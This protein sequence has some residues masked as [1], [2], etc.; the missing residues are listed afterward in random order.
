MRNMPNIHF[1]DHVLYTLIKGVSNFNLNTLYSG[2]Q[3]SL[4]K[5]IL[6]LFLFKRVTDYISIG[7]IFILKVILTVWNT[8]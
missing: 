2:I 8:P 3:K 7:Y 6:G 5:S 1:H 4:L